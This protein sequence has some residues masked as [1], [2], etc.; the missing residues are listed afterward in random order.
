M[1][2]SHLLE[3]TMLVCF[4]FSWPLN[5]R[6][7]YKARTTKGTSLAFIILIISGYLAGIAAKFLNHQINYVLAVYFLNLAIVMSNVFV[8]IRNKKLDKQKIISK[9]KQ[10]ILQVKKDN[11]MNN[12]KEE[13]MNYQ[14]LN[15]IAMQNGVVLLGGTLDKEI[16]V[17]ELS[18]SFA[19]NFKMYNRSKKG[20]SIK[21]A[22]DF[23]D[24]N[25]SSLVPEGIIIHLG[26]EDVE[27]CNTDPE[28]FTKCYMYLINTIKETNKKCRIALVSLGNEKGDKKISAVNRN[29]K[30]IADSEKCTFI[31]LDDAKL[32]NPNSSKAA[33]TFARNLGL[34]VRKPLTDVAEIL[35]SYIYLEEQ[36]L[37]NQ[38][39]TA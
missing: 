3:A 28:M 16:P 35:Y 19:F 31:N 20:L 18:E 33:I 30:A 26:D 24:S 14:E 38:D 6:K 22:K 12:S 11:M 21:N 2:L 9:T 34:S 36:E 1:E 25:I 37:L 27:L 13:K 39:I 7:A 4:G 17:T 32:W 5:V 10:T 8:Y 29:I 15:K 23:F